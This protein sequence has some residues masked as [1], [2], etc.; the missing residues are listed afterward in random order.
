MTNKE[1]KKKYKSLIK[2]ADLA[3]GRKE[4]ISLLHKAE[5]LRSKIH[6][7][8]KKRCSDCNGSG[9]RRVSVEVSKTCFKCFGKGFLNLRIPI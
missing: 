6:K 5:K 7:P 2:S 4:T 9:V 3:N 8:V 1:L